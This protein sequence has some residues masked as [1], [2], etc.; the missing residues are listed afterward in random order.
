[1]R[2]FTSTDQAQRFLTIPGVVD[3]LFRVGR[4][5]MKASYYRELRSRAFFEWQQVTCG[6]F[7]IIDYSAE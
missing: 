2:R 6:K 5:L 7:S 1:M 4:H 3:N